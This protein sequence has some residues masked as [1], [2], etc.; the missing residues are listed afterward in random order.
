MKKQL[1]TLLVL[2]FVIAAIV[3]A[4]MLAAQVLQAPAATAPPSPINEASA[5]NTTPLLFLGNQ[6]LAPIVYLDGTTPTGVDVDL[7]RALAQ[8]MPQPVEIRA[9]N[10]T[11]AQALVA[12]G[13]AD[14]LIQFN[15][16]EERRKIYDFSDPLLESHF[17]IF[18]RTDEVGI[19]GLSSLRGLRV[20]VESASLPQQLLENDPRNVVV[21]IPNFTEAFQQL[22]EGSLDAVVVDYRV[23]SYVLAENNIQNIRV[24][25]DP[26]NSSYAAFGV[27]KGNTRLLNEINHALQIIKSDGTYQKIIDKWQPTET[28]FETQQQITDR[29]YRIT[30]FILLLLCLI[31]VIWSVTIKKDLTR[32]K[33][34]EE[35]MREQFSIL[36]GIIDSAHALIF[37]VD[38][39]YRYTSFNQGHASAMN[40][41]YGAEIEL[42]H[43]LLE[44]MTVE[45]DRNTARSNIDR[46]L[47][48]EQLVKEAYSG[49]GLT[50]Q[51]YFQVSHSPI[52][53][54]DEI[55]GVAVLAQDITDR[56]QA[57][58]ALRR[59]YAEL[60]QRVAERTSDLRLAQEELKKTNDTLRADELQLVRN[61]EDL[62]ALNEEITATQT[63]LSNNVEKLRQRERELT[64]ALAEKEILLSE[65]HHRVKN[66]LTAFIS[67][68]SLEGSHAE[69]EAGLVLRKD[70][71]NRARSM[72]LI[73]ETLYR[74]GKFSTVDMQIYLSTLVSQIADSYSDSARIRTIVEA[75][76]IVFTLGRATTAGLI[77]NELVTNSIKYAFPPEFD[78]TEIRGEPCTI[79]ISITQK[80]AACV[81]TV[82]DNGRGMPAGFDPLASKSLGLKL[83]TFLARHQLRA[84]ISVL[85]E[86]GTEFIFRLENEDGT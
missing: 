75:E 58:E 78:C 38:R 56:K 42:G 22:N 25:G 79:R 73:H 4:G 72:A 30:I 53:S 43:S 67:L 9:M 27:K 70:L 71:Q 33:A 31:A 55:I 12:R 51:R 3:A 6:N 18:T 50:E 77:I 26:I 40:A 7:V 2:G 49:E 28:V 63:E 81:I 47:A 14:A 11:E 84:E 37:S 24:T 66:N 45:E 74:T 39:Q 16:T 65:I 57:E 76:G 19:S 1:R 15:P 10:W 80:N 36:R 54:Q 68:L 61:N 60:E 5:V 8:H 86:K 17:S 69:T 62:N 46:A 64:D 48:G 85:T 35:K 13:D 82:A 32:R 59:L 44:Y 23:G 83:V 29:N 20:G 34:A 52:R 21:I 41:L